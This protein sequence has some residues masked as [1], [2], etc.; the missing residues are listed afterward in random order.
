[1]SFHQKMQH[2]IKSWQSEGVISLE[3]ARVLQQRYPVTKRSMTQTLAL[4]G[5]I[6]LGVGVILFFAANWEVMPRYFKVAVA[7]LSFILASSI[8]YHLRYVQKTYPQVGYALLILGSLLYGAAIWLIG[9]IFHLQ[10]EAAIGFFLWYLGIIPMA[11]LFRSA[12]ILFLAAGNL[13]AWFIAG[14]FPL[15]LPFWLYPLLLGTTI[16]PLTL[17]KQDQVNFTAVL[18]A[19][20]LWFISCGVK[21]AGINHSFT[22]GIT[23]LLLFGLI[24]YVFASLLGEKVFFA[25]DALWFLALTGLFIG[26]LPFTFHNFLSAFLKLANLQYFPLFYAGSVLLIIFLKFKA[27]NISIKD[28]PLILLYLPFLAFLPNLTNSTTLLITNN[29]L[30]FFYTLWIIYTGYQEKSPFVF[31]VGIILFAVAIIFKYFDFFFALMPRSLFFMS[32][33]I[34]LLLGSFYLEHKRRHLLQTMK[35]GVSHV[36]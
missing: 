6:L 28:L 9:Q 32:G 10:P 17:K 26:L 23:S 25:Q 30:L 2:E 27:K 20:Y 24:L 16:L 1:M 14:H 36:E 11:Y 4:L 13:T 5:S 34:L 33:G 15:S 12:L 3:T 31:N 18:I 19:F 21:L 22:L 35:G 8:G 7:L 29:L